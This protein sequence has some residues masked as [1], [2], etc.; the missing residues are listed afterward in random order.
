M[1]FWKFGIAAIAAAGFMFAADG[2]LVKMQA[3]PESKLVNRVN[4]EYPA[5]ALHLRVQ[6]VVKINIVIGADGHIESA[7]LES[8]HPLLWPAAM[9]AVQKWVYKPITDK[10]DLP[11]RVAT[12]V[13][14][15]FGLDEQGK[16]LPHPTVEGGLHP[17]VK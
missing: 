5:D 15:P 8:G 3:V 17:E 10:D 7:H 4:P 1:Q 14:I 11:L 13:S 16:P 6:G 9:Q 12:Q 2:R